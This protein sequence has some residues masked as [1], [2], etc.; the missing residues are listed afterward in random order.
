[1]AKYNNCK[2]GKQ[3]Q[4]QSKKCSNCKNSNKYLAKTRMRS[5]NNYNTCDCGEEKHKGAKQCRS[6]HIVEIREKEKVSY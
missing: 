2:C 5:P 4:E 1:M 6:C 3:K